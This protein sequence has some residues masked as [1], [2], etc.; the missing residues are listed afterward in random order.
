MV[1]DWSFVLIVFTGLFAI[2]N[3]IGNAPI[4]ISFV[5]HLSLPQQKAIALKAVTVG[6]I[7]L[8]VFVI[9]GYALFNIFNISIQAFRITGGL[10]IVKV[11]FDM[12]NSKPKS[13]SAITAI[14]STDTG[15]AISPLATPILI[16]P[17]TLS[18]AVSFVGVSNKIENS[19]IIIFSSAIIL[20]ITYFVFISSTTLVEKIGK[21]ALNV[22]TKIMGLLIASIGIQ[23]IIT[24]I[25]ELLVNYKI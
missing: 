15:F 3:P 24:S 10:L 21:E 6:F 19:I 20:F 17:G 4:F 18:T 2:I 16:G 8:V 1:I 13:T 14:E 9:F 22:V 5:D 7:I 23:M 11:G 25:E 12:I